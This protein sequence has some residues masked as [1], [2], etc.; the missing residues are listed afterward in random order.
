MPL[1]KLEHF[2]VLADDIDA[3]RDFYCLLGLRTG[4]RPPMEFAGY[5]VYA[6]D[7]P[8][9]HIAD[10]SDYE[11]HSRNVGIPVSAATPGTGPVDHLAFNGGD[12][13]GMLALLRDHGI[14]FVHHK[15][16]GAPLQQLFLHD[17]NGVKVE[18]NF[19]PP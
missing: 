18:I 15:P 10:R 4:F 13:E 5:W 7:T 16:A 11:R 6:G 2:L 3:T 19:F 14:P 8:C 9:V 17:P 12:L 1:L